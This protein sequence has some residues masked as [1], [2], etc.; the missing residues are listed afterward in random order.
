MA[1]LS[2]QQDGIGDAGQSA[3][4]GLTGDKFIGANERLWAYDQMYCTGNRFQ[5]S[6]IPLIPHFGEETSG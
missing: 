4:D 2:A 3:M 1:E 5:G 6:V